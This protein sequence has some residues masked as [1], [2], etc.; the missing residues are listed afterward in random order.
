VNRFRRVLERNGFVPVPLQSAEARAALGLSGPELLSEL[1]VVL[2]D[3]KVL[4][5]ADAVVYLLQFLRAGRALSRLA[6]FPGMM[7]LLRRAYHWVAR[8]RSCNAGAC[9]V[10]RNPWTAW[11]PL[12]LLA[13]AALMIGNRIPPWLFMWVLASALFAGCKWLTWRLA[14]ERGR[15]AGVGRTFGYLF[16]WIGMDAPAF[17]RRSP[18]AA[19][20][21]AREW[22][23]AILNVS[24]GAVLTWLIVRMVYPAHELVAGWIGRAGVIFLLHFGLFQL[25]ALAWQNA[26]VDARPLMQWPARACSLADFWGRRWNTAFHQLARDFVFRPA[27]R[28]LNRRAATM[29]VFLASGLV[30]DLVISVPAGGGYGLPTAYFLLQGM[31]VLL[32][33][34]SGKRSTAVPGRGEFPVALALRANFRPQGRR[35]SAARGE[36]GRGGRGWLFTMLVVA[37]PAFWLFHPPFVRNVIVPF[38]KTIGAV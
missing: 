4:G 37:G 7:P 21:P 29:L 36:V 23:S 5:G 24:L 33:R 31:G 26:G 22:L 35:Y 14:V 6:E 25:L 19:K 13:V 8:N 17:L 20:P 10:K 28:K 15:G 16:G 27:A 34:S 11:L 2:R 32:E 30:H 3:G 18:L 9:E 38:L 1:R 12:V